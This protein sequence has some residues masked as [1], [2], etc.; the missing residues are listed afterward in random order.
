MIGQQI[1]AWEVLNDRILE[2]LDRVKRDQYVPAEF[3][4]VAYSDL[5]I[6][7]GHG[8][9]MLEPKV[10]GRLLQS[11]NPAPTDRVLE[12]GTGTGYLTACLSHLSAHVTTVEIL[13]NLHQ[14]AKE[15]LQLNGITNCQAELGDGA[16]GWPDT[17]KYDVIVVTS[18]MPVLHEQL[19]RQL[20]SGGRLFAIVGQP[21]IME[22][23][24]ITRV[25]DNQW[26]T[27]SLFD[28]CAPALIGPN[29]IRPFDV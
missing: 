22:A 7:L 5:Q 10:Q 16:D 12:I 14:S 11:V 27:E 3:V 21:P 25:D 23:L 1:R 2:I 4:D 20:T 6:P 24:L 17:G 9:V 18:S 15:N 8:Q 29:P 19:Q 13:P 26:S 28:T